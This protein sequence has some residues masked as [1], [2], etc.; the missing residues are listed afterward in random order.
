MKTTNTRVKDYLFS[1][2]C[3]GKSE[4]A[5]LVAMLGPEISSQNFSQWTAQILDHR[6]DTLCLRVSTK[7]LQGEGY[8]PD[9]LRD[10][11]ENTTNSKAVRATGLKRN[12]KF[13]F[14]VL[15]TA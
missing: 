15:F 11:G 14:L 7:G 5:K 1:L 4:L 9:Q 13:L 8:D 6:K 12:R 10:N 3:S 2:Q